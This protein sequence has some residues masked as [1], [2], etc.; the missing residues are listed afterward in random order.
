MLAR[1]S[2]NIERPGPVDLVLTAELASLNISILIL[3]QSIAPSPGSLRIRLSAEGPL[4]RGR[5]RICEARRGSKAP[6]GGL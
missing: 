4:M 6:T 2:L 1:G 3:G 5:S